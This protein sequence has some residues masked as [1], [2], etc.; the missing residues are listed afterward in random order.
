METRIPRHRHALKEDPI[1][2]VATS[3]SECLHLVDRFEYKMENQ[4]L[5]GLG[6][7]AKTYN[8]QSRVPT[9]LQKAF[10]EWQTEGKQPRVCGSRWE[11]PNKLDRS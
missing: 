9:D 10:A 7:Y 8:Q 3:I 6:K 5:N 2:P 4:T 1:P 11:V